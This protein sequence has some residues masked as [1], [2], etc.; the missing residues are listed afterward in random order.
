MGYLEKLKSFIIEWNKDPIED[1]WL[2]PTFLDD[3]VGPMTPEEA[4][5]NIGITVNVLIEQS[6]EST[7]L[8]VLQTILRLA[9]QSNTT[10]IPQELFEAKDVIAVQFQQYDDYAKK[11]YDELLHF[12]RW[13]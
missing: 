11:K 6:D 3:V 2:F 9:R 1:E 7:A 10:E 13:N 8:A 12:Y 5:S 4:F